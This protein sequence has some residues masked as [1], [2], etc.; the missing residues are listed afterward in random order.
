MFYKDTAGHVFHTYSAYAR[1]I[2]YLNVA[3]SLPRPGYPRDGMK[4]AM[5]SSILSTDGMMNTASN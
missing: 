2:E 5:N 3:I 1:G 4:T